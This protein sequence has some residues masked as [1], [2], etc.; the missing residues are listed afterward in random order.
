MTRLTWW[1]QWQSQTSCTSGGG[2]NIAA[3]S[4]PP[5]AAS[6]ASG[7]HRSSYL[8]TDRGPTAPRA[9][10]ERRNARRRRA[11]AARSSEKDAGQPSCPPESGDEE[12][13]DAVAVGSGG[14]A[15]AAEGIRVVAVR[16]SD[17]ER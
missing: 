10:A 7:S 15:S 1:K 11:A 17:C 13:M 2:T 16:E 6:A 14:G 4:P 5:P 3:S 12:G 8:R 9:G